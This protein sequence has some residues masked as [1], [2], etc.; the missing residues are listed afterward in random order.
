MGHFA[1][2][3]TIYTGKWRTGHIQGIAIDKKKAIYLLLFYHCS[4]QA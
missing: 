1:L 2:P 4:Y 3:K